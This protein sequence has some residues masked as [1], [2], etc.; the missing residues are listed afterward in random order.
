MS[1]RPVVTPV[2]LRKALPERLSPSRLADFQQCPK[3]FFYKTILKLRTPSTTATTKGTL[4]HYAFE[5]IFDHP[6]GERTPEVA[7]PYVRVHWEELKVKES[8]A[9]V[10]GM[11]DEL[12]ELM[13]L[14]TEEMV[15]G[16]FNIEHP[17]RFDPE[18][19]ERW[20]R[21]SLNS[22][23]IHGIIDRLD[24]FEIE[25]ETRWYISDYKTGKTPDDRYI[26]KAFFAMK[27]YAALLYEELGVVAHELRLV[28]VK[29]GNKEDVRRVR[30]TL[31]MIEETKAQVE[32]IW[33]QIQRAAKSGEFSPKQGP[34]CNWCNF[35]D[36]CPAFHP[37]IAG[38]PV[39]EI[40]ATFEKNQ[41]GE[42]LVQASFDLG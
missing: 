35:Q 18:G 34:L 29:N 28:Y 13:L 8:Y 25:G 16:W 37:E 42:G 3:L 31:A 14:E 12:V 6:R 22:A 33:K 5:H 23:S 39:E 15:K 24:K 30:C 32:A 9:D 20:V 7:V 2:D 19:R 10:A 27:I 41:G 11:G 17:E 26:E 1:P 4:A 38:L 40:I 36:I 21:G